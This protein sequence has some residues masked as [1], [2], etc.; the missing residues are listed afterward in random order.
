MTGPDRWAE[1]FAA[2]L[3]ASAGI[4]AQLRQR[5]TLVADE[6][7]DSADPELWPYAERLRAVL[8]RG[9]A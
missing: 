7:A 2:A 4:D 6:M 3:H 1:G 9:N 8:K 5:L